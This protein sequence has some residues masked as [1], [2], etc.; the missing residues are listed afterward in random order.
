MSLRQALL[1]LILSKLELHILQDEEL[2]WENKQT[3]PQLLVLP[4]FFSHVR[5]P[6]KYLLTK[7]LS[8]VSILKG[9]PKTTAIVNKVYCN[10]FYKEL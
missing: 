2:F 1:T 9:H 10:E 5:P 6:S 4:M 7:L 8:R 3:R